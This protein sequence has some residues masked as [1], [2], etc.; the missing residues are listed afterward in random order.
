MTGNTLTFG[1]AARAVLKH[2]RARHRLKGAV[3][4]SRA[5]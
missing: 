5:Y 2:P 4:A 1:K 3:N